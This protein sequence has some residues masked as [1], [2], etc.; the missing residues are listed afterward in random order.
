MAV[1][2]SM[3]VC[4]VLQYFS[5]CNTYL[6]KFLVQKPIKT[7]LQAY[8][9]VLFVLLSVVKLR[10]KRLQ[11]IA[12]NHL[13]L[14]FIGKSSQENVKIQSKFGRLLLTFQSQGYLLFI[15]AHSPK[16]LQNSKLFVAQQKLSCSEKKKKYRLFHNRNLQFA[17]ILNTIYSTKL[18]CKRI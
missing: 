14:Q 1:L 16:G 3:I 5:S 10:D 8:L 18:N 17:L 4:I 13:Q 2:F 9:G 7:S 6:T 12:R 11:Q 15:I